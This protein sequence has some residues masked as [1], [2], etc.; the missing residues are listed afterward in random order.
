MQKIIIV[1]RKI[2]TGKEIGNKKQMEIQ[3]YEKKKFQRL[4]LKLLIIICIIIF[5][6]T[7]SDAF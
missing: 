3:N 5:S 6:E 2:L 7:K 4:K 1:V